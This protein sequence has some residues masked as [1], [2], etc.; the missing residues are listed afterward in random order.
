MTEQ[1][2]KEIGVRN[3]LG[4]SVFGIVKL[5]SADFLKQ[6]LVAIASRLA[7]GLVRDEPLVAG[8]C[9]QK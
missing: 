1:R 3:V 7:P 5:L 2:R 4:A 8:F 6:V 9:F